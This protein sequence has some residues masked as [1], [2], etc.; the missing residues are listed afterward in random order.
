LFLSRGI[1]GI[2]RRAPAGDVGI[3]AELQSPAA[4]PELSAAATQIAAA[5]AAPSLAQDNGELAERVRLV[6]KREPAL[7]VNVLRM[8]LQEGTFKSS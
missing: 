1:F 8:W 4:L 5:A 3:P 7:T 2:G 6:A